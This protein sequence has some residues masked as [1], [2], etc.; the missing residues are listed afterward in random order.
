M[1]PSCPSTETQLAEIQIFAS[2]RLETGFCCGV[3]AGLEL[4]PQNP[5][6]LASQRAGIAGMGYHRW[7]SVAAFSQFSKRTE[8]KEK[9]RKQR[10]ESWLDS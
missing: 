8:R 7:D 4:L 1:S 2:R 6:L 5:P 10:L 9:T 3:Q